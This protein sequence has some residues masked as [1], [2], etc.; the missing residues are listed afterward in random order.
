MCSA[1]LGHDSG[2]CKGA[3]LACPG[4]L[5]CARA[6]VQRRASR[7][8]VVDQ[9]NNPPRECPAV[10][11]HRKC[12]SD[13]AV[14]FCCGQVGL[15]PSPAHAPQ[16]GDNRQ[17]DVAGKILGLIEAAF[18]ASGGM[19]RNR[20]GDL[21][22]VGHIDATRS[23]EAPERL[24]QRPSPVVLERVND[25]SKD[26]FIRTDRA[27][28]VDRTRHPPATGTPR[29]RCAQDAPGRERIA[30]PIAKRWCERKN[31]VPAV[32]ADG[33]ERGAMQQVGARRALGSEQYCQHRVREPPHG[34]R[35]QRR[36][37]GVQVSLMPM[38]SALPHSRSRP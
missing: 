28:A 6:G 27:R 34:S 16:R 21:R 17:P 31:R 37:G 38:C 15:H 4:V 24:C 32:G 35:S 14:A 8:H 3:N 29:E 11:A 30:A 22:A 5:E 36:A 20:N 25:C 9:D 23:H 19:E 2:C 18:P 1:R 10:P 7:A 33:T 26:A 13:V 12:A